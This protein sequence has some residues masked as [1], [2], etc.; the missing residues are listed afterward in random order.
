MGHNHRPTIFVQ[1][2][3]MGYFV[4]SCDLNG[5]RNTSMSAIYMCMHLVNNIQMLMFS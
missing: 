5:E 1:M 4:A 2:P 3:V